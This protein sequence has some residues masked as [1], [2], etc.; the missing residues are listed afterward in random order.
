MDEVAAIEATMAEARRARSSGDVDRAE[1]LLADAHEASTSLD[2]DHS[3]RSVVGWRHLKALFDL[4]RLDALEAPLARILELD[5]PFGEGSGLRAAEPIARGIWDRLGYGRPTVRRLWR[6]YVAHF[7]AAGDPWMAA[8]GRAQL[9]WDEACSGELHQVLEAVDGI[10]CTTPDAFSGGLSRHPRAVDAASSLFYAQI[11]Q[12]RIA[13][14]AAVWGREEA[15]ARVALELYADAL[16]EAEEPEDYWFVETSARSEHRFG[17]RGD[18][19]DR[20]A[21]AA[22]A[23]DHPRAELHRALVGAEL[24]RAG[25]HEALVERVGD[26]DDAGPEWGVDVRRVLLA[27]DGTDPR[28]PRWRQEADDRIQRFGL[29]VFGRTAAGPAT[30]GT[31]R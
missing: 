19:L 5:E 3:I 21:A 18:A 11:E 7:E 1:E 24:Q 8:C 14:W 27:A 9:L 23:L 6:R 17:W 20:W 31:V 26:A 15:L 30:R 2:R 22:E 16:A 13:S 25:T 4:G 12:A 28:A 10:A 29:G